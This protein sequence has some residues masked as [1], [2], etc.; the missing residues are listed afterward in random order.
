MRYVMLMVMF[1]C[2][3]AVLADDA[4]LDARRA[5]LKKALAEDWEYQLRTFPERATQIGDKRYNDKLTDHSPEAIAKRVEHEK[6]FL[7]KLDRIDTAAEKCVTFV[8]LVT[9]FGECDAP[10]QRA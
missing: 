7:I 2:S 4:S 3:I 9:R 8:A 10:A 1:A 5:E 6:E